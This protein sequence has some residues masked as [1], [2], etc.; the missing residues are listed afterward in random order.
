MSGAEERDFISWFTHCHNGLGWAKPNL[1]ACISRKLQQKTNSEDL[2]Q[3]SI[4]PGNLS[5]CASPSVASCFRVS[6]LSQPFQSS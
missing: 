4:L 5:C 6:A 1:G 2:N 3:A